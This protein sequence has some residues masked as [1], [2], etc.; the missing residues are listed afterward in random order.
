M[1]IVVETTSRHPAFGWWMTDMY[2]FEMNEG[3]A[4]KK[5]YIE[6]SKND[7]EYQRTSIRI[8]LTNDNH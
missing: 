8:V 4:A 5:K 1:R 3:N 2:S 6:L 7:C